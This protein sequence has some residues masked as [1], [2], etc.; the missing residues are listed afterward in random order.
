MNKLF[1][2][3]CFAC[4]KEKADARDLVPALGISICRDC[5]FEDVWLKSRIE[6]KYTC[7][8]CSLSFRA[9]QIAIRRNELSICKSCFESAREVLFESSK[10]TQAATSFGKFVLRGE[11]EDPL[12]VHIFS[13]IDRL[14][15]ATERQTAELYQ[16]LHQLGQRL[17]DNEL[18]PYDRQLTFLLQNLIESLKKDDDLLLASVLMRWLAEVAVRTTPSD[19]LALLKLINLAIV[20]DEPATASKLL[21]FLID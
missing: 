21:P 16:L 19:K 17:D 13:E 2:Q 14:L 3:S 20:C 5:V 8:F 9:R 4:R 11:I 15:A 10:C 12:L 7:G 6:P 18:D 1:P